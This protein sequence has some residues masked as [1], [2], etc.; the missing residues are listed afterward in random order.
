MIE[1]TYTTTKTENNTTKEE[2]KTYYSI[3]VYDKDG[4]TAW[5]NDALAGAT[6]NA[7]VDWYDENA[8]DLTFNEKAYRFIN[9]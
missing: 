2:K 8:L 7:V 4:Y 9:A 1:L 3:L 5:Y 6:D